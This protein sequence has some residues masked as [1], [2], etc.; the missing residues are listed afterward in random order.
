MIYHHADQ[1]YY[2]MFKHL[3]LIFKLQQFTIV[4]IFTL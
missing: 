2:K 4:F 1:K 3:K